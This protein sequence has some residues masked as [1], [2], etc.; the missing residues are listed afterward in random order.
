MKVI[1]TIKVVLR[2]LFLIEFLIIFR[3]NNQI[4][5]ANEKDDWIYI[6]LIEI[7]FI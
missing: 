2:T 4:F 7:I 6:L 3:K 1:Q 5:E